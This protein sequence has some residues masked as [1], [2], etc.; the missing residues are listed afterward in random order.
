VLTDFAVA[1]L[2]SW[3]SYHAE[4]E[5]AARHSFDTFVAPVLKQSAAAGPGGKNR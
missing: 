4:V 1:L 2:K 3:D 5:S